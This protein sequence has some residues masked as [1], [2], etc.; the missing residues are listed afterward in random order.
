MTI[1]AREAAIRVFE[2]SYSGEK[3]CNNDVMKKYPQFSYNSIKDAMRTLEING[4]LSKE[5]VKNTVGQ[6]TYY[7]K[8]F[9]TPQARAYKLFMAI[10]PTEPK[11]K[12][13][14]R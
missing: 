5:T 2:K 9:E 3:F 1:T 7:W 8:A 14:H 12:Y 4:Y 13:R 6:V 11:V 10:K